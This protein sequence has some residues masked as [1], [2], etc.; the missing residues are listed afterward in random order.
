MESKRQLDYDELLDYMKAMLNKNSNIESIYFGS[1]DNLLVNGSGWI[2]PDDF[3]L[4][5][6]PWY[7][8]AINHG[9]YDRFVIK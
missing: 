2:P 5:T 4:R 1:M 3:D 6:R 9:K 8:K 7:V